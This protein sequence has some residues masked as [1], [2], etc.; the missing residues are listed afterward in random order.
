MAPAAN[1]GSIYLQAKDAKWIYENCGV[2]IPVEIYEDANEKAL[3]DY[4]IPDKLAAGANY[5]P[6]VDTPYVKPPMAIAL[7]SLSI[8]TL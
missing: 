7:Y 1:T 5:D 6:S 4:K 8:H 3:L 2:N